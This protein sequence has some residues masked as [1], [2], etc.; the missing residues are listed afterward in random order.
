MV[1]AIIDKMSESISSLFSSYKILSL[2][3]LISKNPADLFKNF[4]ASEDVENSASDVV[5]FKYLPR[6]LKGHVLDSFAGT[7]T[8]GGITVE[9]NI[10]IPMIFSLDQVVFTPLIKYL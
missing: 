1:I 3:F 2:E 6:L 4:N 10:F 7:C 9:G 5:R 8:P